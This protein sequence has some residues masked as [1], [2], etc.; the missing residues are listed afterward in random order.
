MGILFWLAVLLLGGGSLVWLIEE[1]I[2][3]VSLTIQAIKNALNSRRTELKDSTIAIV[4]KIVEQDDGATVLDLELLNQQGNS[5][6]HIAMRGRYS[7]VSTG[8]RI[9]IG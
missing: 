5:N 2:E 9:S 4:Q 6:G 8:N 1:V 7:Y 3:L